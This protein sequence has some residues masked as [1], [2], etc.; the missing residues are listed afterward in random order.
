MKHF[1]TWPFSIPNCETVLGH[2][3]VNS[4]SFEAG[5]GG[6]MVAPVD[7]GPCH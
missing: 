1:A 4:A 5:S 7:G 2:N 3:S 6:I